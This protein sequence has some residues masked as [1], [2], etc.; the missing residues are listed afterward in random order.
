M[1]T[2]PKN[3]PL[4][5]GSLIGGEMKEEVVRQKAVRK[6]LVHLLALMPF[7]LPECGRRLRL[8]SANLE[9]ELAKVA[10]KGSDGLWTMSDKFFKEVNPWEFPYATKT[11]RELSSQNAAR[12]FD[13]L[14]IPS[15]DEI[16]QKLNALEERGKGVTI[17]RL[18]LRSQPIL[19]PNVGASR[20]AVKAKPAERKAPVAKAEAAKKAEPAKKPISA[21]AKPKVAKK[22]SASTANK[23]KTPSPLSSSPP[24]NASDCED[25]HPVHKKLSGVASPA[26]KALKRKAEDV[27]GAH[28]TTIP[29]KKARVDTPKTSAISTLKPKPSALGSTTTNGKAQTIK[30]ANASHQTNG[31]VSRR[32]AHSPPPSTNSSTPGSPIAHSWRQSVDMATKFRRVYAR[33]HK[34]YMELAEAKEAP[35]QGKREELMKMHRTL[36]KMKREING[37]S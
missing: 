2:F 15:T 13:R 14:R 7:S 23:P 20:K 31:A 16:W 11:E 9:P 4:P 22:A 5:E 27:S 19:S 36:E 18:K 10:R 17:S 28:G 24:V 1:S 32:E 35:S 12:A 21:V 34:L 33:Y 29:S 25:H 37:A 8:V 30:R 26:K 3:F 6:S